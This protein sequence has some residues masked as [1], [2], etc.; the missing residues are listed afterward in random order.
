MTSLVDRF[1]ESQSLKTLTLIVH[2]SCLV[3]NGLKSICDITVEASE[4]EV[5]S[6]I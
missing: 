2:D 5:K 1:I 4:I 6:L 3:D